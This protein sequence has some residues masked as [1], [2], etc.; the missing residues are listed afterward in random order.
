MFFDLTSDEA[1]AG[2]R[3]LADSLGI[4]DRINEDIKR[5]DG[6]KK[7]TD[8]ERRSPDMY[9]RSSMFETGMFVV[10]LNNG[11]VLLYCPVRVHDDSRLSRLLDGLGP[12]RYIVMGSSYH[13]L[14]LPS[15][16][17]RYPEAAVIG[18]RQGEVKLRA[19]SALPRGRF[20]HLADQDGQ[21]GLVEVNRL[22]E[23]QGWVFKDQLTFPD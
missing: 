6:V 2:I 20:D 21:K 13:S 19:V 1:V 3:E 4:L 23:P 22:L 18:S 8:A 9:A 7:M 16:V 12:V 11:E 15:V 5:W 17:R 14:H 10:R